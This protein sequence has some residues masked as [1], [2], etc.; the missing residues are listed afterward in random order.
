VGTGEDVSRQ[1][2]NGHLRGLDGLRAVAAMLVVLTHVGFLTGAVSFGLVG[3]VLGRGDLGVAVFFG[4]SGFLLHRSFLRER[5][6]T[7]R[8]AV[9]DYLLRRA[10]RVLPA[11]WVGLVV[12]AVATRPELQVLVANATLTQ[13]YLPGALID[14]YTQTWSLATEASFYVVLP[15]AFLALMRATR[16]GHQRLVVLAVSWVLGVGA[17]AASGLVQVGGEALAGRW[18]PTHWPSFA[19]GMLL[20]EV[21][22]LPRHRVTQSLRELAGSPSTC[23]A[24]GVGAY[25]LATTTVAGPLTLGPLAG[26]QQ[27]GK[28][29][30]GSAVTA[31]LM[32]PLLLGP[33]TDTYSRALSSPAGRYLG[34]IS[35]GVFLWHLPVFEAIYHVTGIDYFTGGAVALLAVGLPLAIGLA[36]VSERWLERP[37][38]DWVHRQ[39]GAR[40]TP[41][42]PLPQPA[43]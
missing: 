9:G 19:L 22:T 18:L 29:V 27:A 23:L 25:L 35:Y 4:L 2:P 42:P 28:A 30:L 7:G 11:F 38:M 43:P 26:L 6:A 31:A 8:V 40:R 33:G 39:H 13:V 41:G 3:R 17:A 12:V 21:V 16:T 34:R 15:F 14:G 36:A 1:T 20:S 37:V 32:V 5:A 24:V 10:A